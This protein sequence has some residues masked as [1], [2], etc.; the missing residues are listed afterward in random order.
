MVENGSADEPTQIGPG[1]PGRADRPD[2][3]SI[4]SPQPAPLPVSSRRP[5]RRLVVAGAIAALA[6][7]SGV[8]AWQAGRPTP[9]ATTSPSGPG[10]GVAPLIA[11]VD[12]TGGLVAVD[13]AGRR[14]TV[15]QGPGIT[16]GFPAWSPDGARLAAV[17]SLPGD[18]AV[19]VYEIPR[20]SPSAPL[21]TAGSPVVAFRSSTVE[22]F[23]L[24]WTPDGRQVTF[25]ANEGSEVSLRIAPAD[26][27]AP[28]DGSG[29]GA[30]IRRGAPLY[31]DFVAKDRLVLHVGVG[32]DAFLG[33]V[34]LDGGERAPARPNP[35]DFRAPV[36]GTDG[37][38][39]A[40]VRGQAP[41]A[42]LVV[43][44]RDGS[45]EHATA[46][47]GPTATVFDPSGARVASIAP[48]DPTMAALA[49]P[50]GPLRLMDGPSG[51]VRT[52]LDGSVVGFWWAPDGRTI[53]AL[54]LQPGSGSTVAGGQIGAPGTVTAAIAAAS[55]SPVPGRPSNPEL[56]LVFVTVEGAIRSDRTI[57]VT[58]QFVNQ[59]LPY[60]DQYALSHRVWS[61]DSSAI[62]L[63]IV[64]GAGRDRVAVLPADG[65]DPP[66]VLEGSSGFW[67]P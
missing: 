61:P 15:A 23:Y 40:F 47:A 30:V 56:H 58:R 17:R 65:G 16:S 18:D 7:A 26:G 24:Y 8:V 35:G 6:V 67:S 41:A 28:L 11:L 27:S 44:A 66:L 57:Q 4:A 13:L 39:V 54:R 32:G 48:A 19:A 29:P 31:F 14:T 33:E 38:F 45:V 51:E 43:A 63:P 21:A 49:F 64:D 60:F 1:G 9:T 20:G 62:V 12:P 25:L 22:P 55:P 46:V 50:I 42:E 36:V 52:L 37:R 53:A 2:D 10:A 34:G 3:A 5:A 59:Y